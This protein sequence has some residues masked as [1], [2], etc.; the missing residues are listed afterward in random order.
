[1]S[2]AEPRLDE[3]EAVAC[4]L[5]AALEAA[6]RMASPRN[7]PD[8]ERA[9]WLHALALDLSKRLLRVIKDGTA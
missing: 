5:E 2:P 3:A 1:M 9:A 8:F 6:A 4:Q 7:T